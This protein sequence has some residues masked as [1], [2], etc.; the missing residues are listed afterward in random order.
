VIVA[1]L[2]SSI[3]IST[4]TL[5]WGFAEAGFVIFARWILIF[6][7]VWLFTQ[8]R[9]WGWFSSLGLF[10]AVFASAF[11]FWFGFSLEWL[12]SGTIFALFAW[13][14]SNFHKRLRLM[15]KDSETHGIERRHLARISLLAFVGLFLASITM[16]VR[17]RFTF[18]WGAL[19]MVV[20]LLGL[21][22]LVGWFHR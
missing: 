10:F 19:L 15:A 21:G 2:V 20:I 12:F 1:A 7:A 17:V 6:G 11:G 4:G 22:Q 16:F 18:E 14:I 9:G 8:W 5:A 3:V 13:D